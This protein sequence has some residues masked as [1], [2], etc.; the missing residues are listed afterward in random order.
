MKLLFTILLILLTAASWQTEAQTSGSRPYFKRIGLQE[1]MPDNS[2]N[3]IA[4]DAK[5]FLLHPGR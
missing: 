3:V 1:G 2:V 5:G 4:Q